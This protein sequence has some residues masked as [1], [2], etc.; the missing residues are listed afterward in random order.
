[1]PYNYSH[2]KAKDYDLASFPGPRVGDQMPDFKLTRIDGSEVH[3]SEL[4]DKRLVLET[5]SVTCPMY[6]ARVPAMKRLAQL[7]PDTR[8]VVLY[9]REAHPGERLGPHSSDEQKHRAASRL[10]GATHESREILVDDVAGTAHLA[11]GGLPDVVYVI[12]PNGR[13]VFRADWNDTDAL[14][15]VLAGTADSDQLHRDHFPPAKPT[16][17]LAVRTLMI[18]GFQAVLDFAL[19]LPGLVGQHRRADRPKA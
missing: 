12:D 18:G 17:K 7:H 8:F 1:M 9:V 4:R 15:A 19:G 2:F 3:L 13:V 10:P 5:G 11:L 14:A 16:P 6:S